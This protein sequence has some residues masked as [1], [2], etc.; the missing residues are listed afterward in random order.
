MSDVDVIRIPLTQG[1]FA[2]VSAE[3]ADLANFNWQARKHDSGGYYAVR[4]N[5]RGTPKALYLHRVILSRMLGRELTRADECDHID[6]DKL[7][8]QRSN[9]RLATHSENVR[10]RRKHRDNSSGYKGVY[11]SK[12]SYAW[13]AQIC[14]H[15]K[16]KHL[17]SYKTPELAYEAY[18]KAAEIYHGDFARIDT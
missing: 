8:N 1:Q 13:T 11:L 14:V 12:K 16:I 6:L 4:G 10:N 9:L 7:N 18:C 3:D 15:G 2:I 17:G 5:K